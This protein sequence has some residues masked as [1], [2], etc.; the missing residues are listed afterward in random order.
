MN[1]EVHCT[2]CRTAYVL[3]GGFAGTTL[4][5]P[6]CGAPDGLTV[7]ADAPEPPFRIAR[8]VAAAV[9]AAHSS[10]PSVVAETRPVPTPPAASTGPSPATVRA[11]PSERAAQRSN[12]ADEVVCPRCKLH[13]VPRKGQ[14]E[15]GNSGRR[16]VLVVE[17]MDYFREIA[18]E[19]LADHFAV[20]QAADVGEARALLDAEEFDLLVL[21]PE[22][23]GIELLR[24]LGRKPCPIL[25]YTDRDESEIYGDSW[26]E[27][28]RYG[29]DDIVMKAMNAGETL[30][31]K[32]SV[33]LGV[34]I[35]ED[36]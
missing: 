23:G 2:D 10:A 3:E 22:S 1:V 8:P 19:A 29:A 18:A 15:T 36:E 35:D 28:Q 4:P 21:D 20:K 16:S 30:A 26:D 25:V 32:A 34:R 17:A 9:T 7:P 13:F 31:R 12:E 24:G 6:A 33:L 5:C 11:K 27:L 14:L